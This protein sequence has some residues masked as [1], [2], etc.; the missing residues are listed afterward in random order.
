MYARSRRRIGR[1]SSGGGSVSGIRIGRW[2]AAAVIVVVVIVGA[3]CAI[4]VVVVVN[5]S[6]VGATRIAQPGIRARRKIWITL[7][8][9]RI[10]AQIGDIV[11]TV[12]AMMRLV[13][14][15]GG[16]N[17]VI[18]MKKKKKNKAG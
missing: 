4:I 2:P 18:C 7:I 11:A 14:M 5:A 3:A 8:G 12:Q 13:R 15:Q 9:T 10:V 1:C 16:A 17:S 6:V